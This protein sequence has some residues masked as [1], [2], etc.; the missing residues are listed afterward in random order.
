[1][2]IR[3]LIQFLKKHQD[4]IVL[5]IGVILI[6]LLSFAVGYIIAKEQLKEPLRIEYE[7]E[8][9]NSYYWSRNHRALLGMEVVSERL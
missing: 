1:M 9:K 2:A 8:S 7:Q 3:G 5:F 6:S 4:D